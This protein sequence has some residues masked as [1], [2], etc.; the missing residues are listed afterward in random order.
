MNSLPLASGEEEQNHVRF[1]L[2]LIAVTICLPFG[3]NVWVD[4]GE[5]IAGHALAYGEGTGQTE[6]TGWVD[7]RSEGKQRK[8][9]A[10]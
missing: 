7:G 8:V 5:Q 6:K 2:R 10:R 4:D 1:Q 3:D 9:D